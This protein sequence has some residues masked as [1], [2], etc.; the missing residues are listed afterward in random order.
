[1]PRLYLIRH[2]RPTS[3]WGQG[4]DDPGL[5][6]QGQA[7][8]KAACEA[9]LGLPTEV[10]PQQVA[11]SPLRRCRETARPLAAALGRDPEIIAA[12]GEIPTP[13][14]LAADARPAWL[15]NAFDG[16]WADIVGDLDYEAWRRGV[17]ESL[18]SRGRTA[19]FSHY[20]AIN[21]VVSLLTGD[22]RV[23]AFRPDH[24]S[25]TELETDGRSL[26]LIAKGREAVTSVL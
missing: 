8:A 2:A 22:E 1:M 11:S 7:Q 20:L 15:A 12:V 23:I 10:R 4:D 6:A 5:D 26:T 14:A 18:L 9:L 25:I 19:V 17:A 3:S 24:A 16:C 13:R 21:A